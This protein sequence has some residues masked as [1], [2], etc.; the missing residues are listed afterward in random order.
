M[1]GTGNVWSAA[2]F[3]GLKLIFMNTLSPFTP[4][5]RVTSVPTAIEPARREMLSE[6]TSFASII[7]VSQFNEV[8]KYIYI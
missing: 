8:L 2:N 5:L 7:M 1:E 3:H 6:P 4:I